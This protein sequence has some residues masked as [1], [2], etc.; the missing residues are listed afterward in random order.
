MS[1]LSSIQALSNRI[2]AYIYANFSQLIT[3][4]VL[5]GILHDISDTLNNFI[6]NLSA[7]KLDKTA[8]G[9]DPVTGINLLTGQTL[10]IGGIDIVS[11]VISGSGPAGPFDASENTLP[12][13]GTG[14]AGAIKNGN[15]W[16]ITV[17]STAAI[18]GLLPK[19]TLD[20]GDI[21]VAGKDGAVL[22]SDFY[23]I[24]GDQELAQILSRLTVIETKLTTIESGA[25]ADQSPDEIVTALE[26]ITI[27][28][29]KL[30]ASAIQNIVN[31]PYFNSGFPQI[32]TILDG[33]DNA[34][35]N[36]I[37]VLAL[38]S[39]INITDI[40]DNLTSIATDKPLS[41][42]QGKALKTL[43]D[44]INSA[45]ALLASTSYVDG[46]VSA[47]VN[48][49][50]GVLDTLKE[51]ADAL[52]DDPNFATTIS[53]QIGA[54]IS[55]SDIIDVLTSVDST[56]PL[57]AKQGNALKVLI[58]ALQSAV[59]L[60]VDQV[61]GKGLSTNDYTTTEKNK[62]A[63]ITGTNTGDQDLSGKVDKIDGKG[64]STNDYTTTEKNKLAAISG[65]NTGDQD[66]SGLQLKS[67]KNQ[68]NGYAGLD[69]T[70]KV[71]AAQLP[72]YV[73]DV[74]EFA[75]LAAFPG[76]GETGKIYTALDTNKIY[77]WSGS[78]YVVIAASP[79]STD[80]V[81]EGSTNLYFTVA[82]AIGAI[83]GDLT[84]LIVNTAISA[85]DSIKV[86]LG[87][88]QGQVNNKVDQVAGKG[89]STNDYTTGEKNKLAAISGTNTGDQ[90]L[91]GKEDITDLHANY[92][93]KSDVDAAIN[94][95]LQAQST[96]S[97][98]Y[99]YQNFR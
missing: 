98:I 31:A 25:T 96:F 79:G 63:A 59:N 38:A 7:T 94:A 70:G 14:T 60:K 43:I 80:S 90:D 46:K 39:K 20:V 30:D 84:G 89:L 74:L 52:G 13:V 34:N 92:Y 93:N 83:I 33:L 22:A 49:A 65:T 47:L 35:N 85:T 61:T 2:N 73:D 19:S 78:V 37:T 57:S 18:T 71:A 88:L 4:P 10:K 16:R 5:Q 23:S 48:S 27:D 68:A 29:N 54:K 91:S 32:Q 1:I 69:S 26:S 44:D 97:V 53:G 67:E 64:L 81:T 28:G 9:Y 99:A 62:L 66:L 41:A 8:I 86:S 12:T 3:G 82:R 45:M 21:I 76:T 40:I 77:R 72:S 6:S 17:A 36:A 24:P 55:T 56:K 15:F 75:N 51:L 95:A 42:N 87:K 58:D 50:P 11:L